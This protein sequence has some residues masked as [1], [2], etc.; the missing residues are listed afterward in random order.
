MHLLSVVACVWALIPSWKMKR[1][2]GENPPKVFNGAPGFPRIWYRLKGAKLQFNPQQSDALYRF[3]F[4][5]K[6]NYVTVWAHISF[7]FIYFPSPAHNLVSTRGLAFCIVIRKHSSYKLFNVENYSLD[8]LRR[9]LWIVP[10]LLRTVAGL[11][12]VKRLLLKSRCLD[13]KLCL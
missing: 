2:L 11:L 7:T 8:G 4:R 5:P 9:P 1:F 6:I 12:V 3:C 10:R 13:I